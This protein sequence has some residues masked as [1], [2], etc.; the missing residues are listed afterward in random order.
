MNW[1]GWWVIMKNYEILRFEAILLFKD[2]D[3]DLYDAESIQ[4]LLQRFEVYDDENPE[5]MNESPI[6]IYA[7]YSQ[8]HELKKKYQSGNKQALIDAIQITALHNLIMP[9]W[10]SNETVRRI[11]DIHH[12]KYKDWSDVF[13]TV[14][15]KGQRLE[16]LRKLRVLPMR[17]YQDVKKAKFDGVSI[18]DD[19]ANELA[20]KYNITRSEVW[21]M[22]KIGERRYKF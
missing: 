14:L 3:F 15:K 13:G 12:Y 16:K 5:I 10:L 1:I 6:W 18:N 7:G 21:E 17:I 2:L 4:P 19:F 11:R 9:E 8:L 20:E 22:K